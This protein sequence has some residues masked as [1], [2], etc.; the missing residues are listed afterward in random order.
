MLFEKR[1][2]DEIEEGR[3]QVLANTTCEERALETVDKIRRAKIASSTDFRL[4]MFGALAIST[5]VSSYFSK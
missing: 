5:A 2:G 1:R 3:N 4:C